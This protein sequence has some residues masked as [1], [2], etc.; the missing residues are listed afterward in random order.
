MRA[1]LVLFILLSVPSIGM[2]QDMESVVTD[3]D[4]VFLK[5]RD[6]AFDKNYQEART[7]LRA[8][9]AEYPEYSDVQNLL[10]KTFSWEGQF[11]EARI[12]FEQIVEHD[13]N[14][15]EVW[16]AVINNE[17]YAKNVIM[18][19]GKVNQALEYLPGDTELLALK[20]RI[21]G[22]LKENGAA[23]RE[24]NKALWMRNKETGS[25]V[26]NLGTFSTMQV[27]DQVFDTQYSLGMEYIRQEKFGRI[28]P[29]ITFANRFG[30]DGIQYE[31]DA[32]PKI[33]DQ[34]Y[35]YLNYGY[36]GSPILARHRVGAEVY[37]MLSK[38]IELSAGIRYLDFRESTATTFTSSLGLY[39]GN[40]YIA[41]RPM[42]TPRSD[43]PT[44][45]FGSVLVRR[46]G[47][48]GDDWMG[49]TFNAGVEPESQQ[50]FLGSILLSESTRYVEIQEL[51]LEYQFTG[52][53]LANLY[54][55]SA[56][57]RHQ[58]FLGEPGTYFWAVTAGIRYYSRF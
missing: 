16:V 36:S 55:A 18:A 32:Y 45:Y 44:A 27:F 1:F 6:L 7:L 58:E 42:I 30:Q 53:S 15:R 9:L 22:L 5:A 11:E 29:R 47:A 37:R 23:M 35:A 12:H 25:F 28:I 38:T 14:N 54:R 34:S 31:I 39:T 26:N 57:V 56:G 52:K 8:I 24:R 51:V 48:T 19:L 2:S 43:N 20:D 46:Y 49:A 10:A 41:A 33:Q 50:V 17:I 21:D 3:P 13:T 4:K 40:Y